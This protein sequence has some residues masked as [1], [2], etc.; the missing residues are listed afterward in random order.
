MKKIINF[1]KKKILLSQEYYENYI[2]IKDHLL[3]KV[4]KKELRNII[5][6][7]TNRNGR[8]KGNFGKKW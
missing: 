3:K 5:K 1:P 6:N 2:K 4:N 8:E 7:Y